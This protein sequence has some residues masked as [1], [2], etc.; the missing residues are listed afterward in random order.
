MRLLSEKVENEIPTET[1]AGLLFSLVYCRNPH[2]L[3]PSFTVT[4]VRYPVTQ[5]QLYE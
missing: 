5:S 3:V 2:L 1:L 4:H